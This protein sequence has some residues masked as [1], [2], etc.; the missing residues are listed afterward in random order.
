LLV[1]V[2][3]RSPSRANR[4]H[5][6]EALFTFEDDGLLRRLGVETPEEARFIDEEPL[7]RRKAFH[8]GTPPGTN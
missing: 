7:K 6:G 2:L 5:E 4:E 3:L 8:H 1:N